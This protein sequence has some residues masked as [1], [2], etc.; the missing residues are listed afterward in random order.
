[1][2]AVGNIVQTDFGPFLN[3]GSPHLIRWIDNINDVNVKLL[4][5]TLRYD[6]QFTPGGT[7]VNFAEIMED[8]IRVRTYERGVEDET[9]SCGTGVTAAVLA[10]AAKLSLNSGDVKV[11]TSGGILN[12]SF[13]RKGPGFDDIWLTGP[14]EMAFKGIIGI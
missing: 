8:A 11:I 2:G 4:G 14:A 13:N 1:M 5:R 9:L 6:A 12:V 7:N 10:Y 3:T